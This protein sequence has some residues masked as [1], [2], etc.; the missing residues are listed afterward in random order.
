V[1]RF[2]VVFGLQVARASVCSTRGGTLVHS[3]HNGVVEGLAG[4]VDAMELPTLGGIH[5]V[6]QQYGRY[7]TNGV[8]TQLGA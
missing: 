5:P 2:G 1:R 7:L 4:D 3:S 6:G 8:P